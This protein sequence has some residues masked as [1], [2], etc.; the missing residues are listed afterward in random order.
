MSAG[1]TRF[2]SLIASICLILATPVQA[3]V[4]RAAARHQVPVALLQA[5]A[6]QESGANPRALNVNPNGTHDIGLMQINSSWLPVLQRHG[7]KEKDLWDPCVN[8]QVAA[9][10]LSENFRRWGY[11]YRAL[12]AYHSPDA[13]RQWRYAN[14]VLNRLVV[15][16][17]TKPM[18][19]D[20]ASKKR[21][22]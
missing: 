14:Q 2:S 19:N 22:P 13:V 8:A 16:M 11:T 21:T 3:C 4:E 15:K 10:L 18:A 7:V 5:I 9:W 6:W 1:L 20:Q 12:G 17:P